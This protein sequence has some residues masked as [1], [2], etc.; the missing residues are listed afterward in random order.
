M[1][2]KKFKNVSLS[3]AEL[4]KLSLGSRVLVRDLHFSKKTKEFGVIEKEQTTTSKI[5]LFSTNPN[6][7]FGYVEKSKIKD[8]SNT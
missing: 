6:D 1:T 5:P 7:I 4:F 8:F 3:N 2:D